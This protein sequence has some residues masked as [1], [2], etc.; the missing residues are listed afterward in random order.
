MLFPFE[1]LY[2]MGHHLHFETQAI[3]TQ[4]EQ[5]QQK[6]HSNPLFLTSSFTFETAEE[7]AALFQGQAGNLYSRFSNPNTTELAKKLTLLEGAEDGIVT[8]SGM[9]AVS[10]SFLALLNPGDHVI[11]SKSIFGNSKYILDTILPKMNISVTYV[12]P[13]DNLS[14]ESAV[15]QKTAMLFIETPSNPTLSTLDMTFLGSLCKANDIIFSVDNCFA[16]PY[17]QQPIK[18]GADLVIHSATKYIDGQG[19]VLGGGIVGHTDLV[20]KCY[21][22][23]R[24]TG[25]ALSPFNAWVLSKSLETLA[26]RMDRHCANAATLANFLQDHSEIEHTYYPHLESNPLYEVA[27]TQMSQGGGLVGCQIKGGKE[28]A[29]KFLNALS[30]HTL[31][32]NLGDTRSIATH[33]ASTTH[34]KL[35]EADQLSAEITPGFLRFS[36]GLEHIEDIIRDIDQAILMSKP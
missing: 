8:A 25:A 28:R 35:S 24:R 21:E 33:P 34:S 31:T 29:A 13:H 10:T 11:S 17:L 5:T 3:R 16:T 27:I 15:T 32:A 26:V 4:L 6:E 19:R 7:G 22:Y 23:I 14:W 9:A 36:V 20:A 12:S 2:I 30:M 1:I 18:F